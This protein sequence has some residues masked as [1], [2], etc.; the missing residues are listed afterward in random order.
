MAIGTGSGRLKYP[1]PLLQTQQEANSV[2]ASAGGSA[3]AS[4][5][6]ANRSYAANKMRVMA[7]LANSAMDRQQRAYE[8]DMQRGYNAGQ[9]YLDRQ[10]QQTLQADQQKFAA[11]QQAKLFGQQNT[12]AQQNQQ[13]QKEQNWQDYYLN[14]ETNRQKT[15]QEQQVQTNKETRQFNQAQVAQLPQIPEYAPPETARKLQDLRSGLSQ[16][17]SN[18]WDHKDPYWKQ[19]FGEGIDEYNNIVQ[20]IPKPQPGERFDQK[21]YERNGTLYIDD[22]KTGLPV[23]VPNDAQKKA[24]VAQKEEQKASADKQAED[25]KKR[26]DRAGELMKNDPSMS[27]QDAIKRAN[28]IQ[29]AFDKAHQERTSGQQPQVPGAQPAPAPAGQP[30]VPN[31]PPDAAGQA[32]AQPA[33]GQPLPDAHVQS[34]VSDIRGAT[35]D[36]PLGANETPALRSFMDKNMESIV[37]YHNTPLD[38]VPEKERPAVDFYG[39]YLRS[40]MSGQPIVL[41]TPDEMALLPP[42]TPFVDDKGKPRR[43]K[44]KVGSLNNPRVVSKE[45]MQRVLQ[46]NEEIRKRGRQ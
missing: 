8:A 30:P 17:T 3:S 19:A 25:R 7:D 21:T 12:L 4:A 23:E 37:K 45:E 11:D 36:M 41:R 42:D 43:T 26:E 2:S 13:F 40:G 38:Q 46:Q 44:G 10:Q 18:E 34:A 27:E 29:D 20:S 1:L 32:P 9:A 33:A 24:A 39:R 6:G 22:P 14:T 5:Y 16:L 35:K 28:E 15:A 31:P